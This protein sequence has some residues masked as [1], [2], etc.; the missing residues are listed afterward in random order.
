MPTVESRELERLRYQQG[1]TIRSQD[2]RDQGRIERQL[3]AWHNR[4][5]HNVYGVAK[6]ILE[7][8]S[9]E[10]IGD[11]VI[12]HTGLA[13]DCFGRELLLC[14]QRSIPFGEQSE[15]MFLVLRRKESCGCE[16]APTA[17]GNCFGRKQS[18]IATNTELIWLPVR[19]FSFGDGVPIARTLSGS[20]VTLDRDYV[21]PAARPLSRPRI[22]TGTTIPGAT[23]W[24]VW[25][26]KSLG[27][28]P[29]FS[30]Q[31]RIDTSSAGFTTVP[32]YFATL[33]GPLSQTNSS[34]IKVICL[35]FDH[36]DL[37]KTDSF[38]FRFLILVINL[39]P[40]KIES[41][42]QKYLQEQKAY[43]GWLG[44]ERNPGES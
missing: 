1:Q 22:G 25:D 35:H 3:L 20:V 36:L 43:V 14:S 30:I 38:V 12:V 37:L 8:L 28:S 39:K 19:G 9:T 11:H 32:Q 42:V 2:F 23:T 13:Y 18:L 5:L 31:V 24:E 21:S 15:P 16:Q 44:I 41:Q 34:G 26:L 27:G 33:Q 10:S 6:E 29:L 7:G 40:F 17:A 4:A